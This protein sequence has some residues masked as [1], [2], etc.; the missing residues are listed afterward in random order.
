MSVNCSQVIYQQLSFVVAMLKAAS[1]GTQAC[2][3]AISTINGIVGDL[4]TTAMFAAAGALNPED[5]VK[6]N[7][8]PRREEILKT[9]KVLVEDTK[10]LVSS[11]GGSQEQL[12][13][14]AHL[15]VNTITQEAEAV[16]LGATALG[17]DDLEAQ[18]I[19][20]D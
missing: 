5:G 14:A 1:K 17:S 9:A 2:T 19:P 18:V 12:A 4:E 7:F 20:D 16:K 10:R 15:A 11:A 3:E 6:G 13:E 8:A